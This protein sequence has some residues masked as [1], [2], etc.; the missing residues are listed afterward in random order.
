[1]LEPDPIYVTRP[2]KPV[3]QMSEEE[4]RQWATEVY[5]ALIEAMQRSDE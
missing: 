3:S 4:R 1:V 5:D 2:P